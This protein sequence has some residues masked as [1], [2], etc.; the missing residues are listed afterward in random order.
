MDWTDEADTDRGGQDTR[1]SSKF[2]PLI[3]MALELFRG[4]YGVQGLGLY[5]VLAWGCLEFMA[6]GCLGS[7]VLDCCGGF[8]VVEPCN[9]TPLT[10]P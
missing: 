2:Q 5:T 1:M 9:K 4:L 10:E 7:G 6:W 3:I 8:W